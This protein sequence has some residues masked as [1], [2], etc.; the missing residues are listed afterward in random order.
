MLVSLLLIANAGIHKIPEK[1]DP[2][3][4]PCPGIWRKKDLSNPSLTQDHSGKSTG[5]QVETFIL[6]LFFRFR[7]HHFPSVMQQGLCQ[8]VPREAPP[9]RLP[10]AGSAAFFWRR[11]AL[12]GGCGG[13]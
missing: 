8:A 1:V 3:P 4:Q 9:Y 7:N 12:A 13:P 11:V 6:N 5:F 2:W 10:R